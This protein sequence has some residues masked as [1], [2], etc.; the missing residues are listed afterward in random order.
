M[1]H[2]PCCPNDAADGTQPILARRD[3]IAAA[4]GC[5]IQRRVPLL[6]LG[7][8]HPVRRGSAYYM[9]VQSQP[10]DHLQHPL[11]H[12]YRLHVTLLLRLTS[13]GTPAAVSKQYKA[14]L[15]LAETHLLF[16]STHC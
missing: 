5:S 15:L 4:Q 6:W 12:V 10:R 14:V 13:T 16:G 2:G 8:R 9:V 3:G 7:F 1:D 11:H